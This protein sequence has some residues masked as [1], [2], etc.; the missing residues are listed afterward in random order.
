MLWDPSSPSEAPLYILARWFSFSAIIVAIGGLL[1]QR[2]LG[3]AVRS[4]VMDSTR[5]AVD[6]AVQR[7]TIAAAVGVAATAVLRFL[8][9]RAMLNA[10]FA[11][12]VVPWGDALAGTFGASVGLQL[13]GAGLSVAATVARGGGGG[14]T[15]ALAIGTMAVSPGLSGHAAAGSPAALSVGADGLHM[16]TAGAWVGVLALLALVAMPVVRAREPEAVGLATRAMVAAFSPVALGSVGLLAIT[17]TYAAWRLVGS[18]DALFAT[19]YGAALLVKL[20]LL[21]AMLVLGAINWRRL[22]PTSGTVA[23][24]SRF[25]RAALAELTVAVLVLLVTAALVGRPSPV[26]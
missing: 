12:D 1:F 2:M 21:V 7:A 13:A 6:T 20:T 17:G 10:A 24:S 22:G 23:G 18:L 9:Q 16:I 14:T 15:V 5:A 25:R 3:A 19:R 11:P 4:A 8:A 26:E